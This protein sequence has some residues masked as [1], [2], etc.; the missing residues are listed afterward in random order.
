[1]RYRL[2]TIIL[3]YRTADLTIPCI[4]SAVPDHQQIDNSIIVVVDN[5]SRDGSADEIAKAIEDNGWTDIVRLIRSPV[6]G[7]FAAGNN[8]ALRE[9]EADRYLLLNSDTIVYSGSIVELMAA[10]DA[11]SDV[12]LVG[13]RIEW[14]N[15]RAQNTCY[16]FRTPIT[17]FLAAARSEPLTRMFQSHV[18]THPVPDDTFE[19]D[20]TSFACC[21]IRREVFDQVGLLDGGYFMY[22]DDI[23]FCCRANTAGWKVMF[24]PKARIIHLRGKSGPVK[25][26]AAQ[27][28]RRPAYFYHSRNRYFAK[29]FGRLGMWVTNLMWCFGRAVSFVRELFRTKEPHTCEHEMLDIWAN[30]WRPMKPPHG[31]EGAGS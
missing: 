4:E 20:W 5:D 18:G 13:P 12:G 26:L 2:S 7:G 29:N 22:F 15:G 30:A 24:W 21:L 8:V 3:N 1:M 9:I 31:E 16:R 14:P 10:L 28:K 23:D 27:R 19:T 6:N 11:R 17:E 25:E